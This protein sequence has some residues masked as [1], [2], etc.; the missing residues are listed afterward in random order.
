[1]RRGWPGILA[2]L[3]NLPLSL[4]RAGALRGSTGTDRGSV[5]RGCCYGEVP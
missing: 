4:D 2:A 5:P 3:E 1:M